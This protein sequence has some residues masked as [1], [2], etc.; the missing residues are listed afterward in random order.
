MTK[1]DSLFDSRSEM[2]LI[3]IELV[4]KLL[5]EVDDHPIPYPLKWV[6][7]DAKLMVTK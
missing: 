2:N 6:S 3:T 4:K 1:I 7:N 5:L